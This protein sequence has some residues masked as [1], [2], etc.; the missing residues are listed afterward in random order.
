MVIAIGT[1]A[2]VIVGNNRGNANGSCGRWAGSANG[3]C[4]LK[5][6]KDRKAEIMLY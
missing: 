3:A 6:A 4:K 5:F 1:M 2:A